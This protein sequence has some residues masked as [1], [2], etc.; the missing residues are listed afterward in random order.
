MSFDLAKELKFK[1]M[2]VY[3]VGG[4]GSWPPSATSQLLEFHTYEEAEE[5]IKHV[6]HMNSVYCVR[7]Y[8]LKDRT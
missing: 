3:T 6:K 1:V 4:T 2:A 8:K 5:A 7:F